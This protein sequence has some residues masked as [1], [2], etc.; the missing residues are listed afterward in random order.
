MAKF[1]LSPEADERPHVA[2]LI[3]EKLKGN[4]DNLSMN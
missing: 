1:Q 4:P 2:L 3:T